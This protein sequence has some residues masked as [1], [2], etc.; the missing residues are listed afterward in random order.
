MNAY[1][2]ARKESEDLETFIFDSPGG[3]TVFVFTTESEA[4]TYIDAADLHR[5]FTIAE[6]A[7]EDFAEWMVRCKHNGVNLIGINP[8]H[9]DIA[10]GKAVDVMDV[11]AHLTHFAEHF[12]EIADPTF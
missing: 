5:E 11:K 9:D 12:L 8:S 1:V 2:I 7:A 3:D 6:I 10:H 4:K